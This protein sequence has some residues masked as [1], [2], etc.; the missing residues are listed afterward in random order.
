MAAA[1][2]LA[3]ARP[4]LFTRV[5]PVAAMVLVALNDH[6]LKGAGLL[7]GWLTGKLSDFAGLYFAPLLVA[8]LWTLARPT[9]E[10]RSVVR[11][12][13]WAALGVGLLFTAIKTSPPADR[14]YEAVLTALLRHPASNTVDPTDLIALV[15]L[16]VA[17]WDARRLVH[18]P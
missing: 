14:L 12:V 1:T 16:A 8:E 7:P 3:D 9:C 17:I 2:E 13:T 11:R 5:L 6:V 15:M 10:A 4:A 18:S